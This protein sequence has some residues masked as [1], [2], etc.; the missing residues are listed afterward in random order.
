M[1]AA[2]IGASTG[3][4]IRNRTPVATSIT[5]GDIGNAVIGA[6]SVGT[7]N[8]NDANREAPCNCLRQRNSWLGCIPASRAT[9]DN[10]TR[11]HRGGNDALLLSSRPSPALPNRSHYLDLRLRHWIAPNIHYLNLSITGASFCI[12]RQR[13]NVS[14]VFEPRHPQRSPYNGKMEPPRRSR[15]ISK[16]LQVHTCSRKPL[17]ARSYLKAIVLALHLFGIS[18]DFLRG[19]RARQYHFVARFLLSFAL[20]RRCIRDPD[21]E[22]IG[23]SARNVGRNPSLIRR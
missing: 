10:C 3:P 23:G 4:Q 18:Q 21:F 16:S 1:T 19:Y 17:L 7:F 15:L 6:V 20:H 8:V 12:R 9:A 13:L 14:I 2:T 5:P 11:L 22:P